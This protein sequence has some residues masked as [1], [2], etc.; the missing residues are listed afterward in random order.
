MK[1]NFAFIL[2]ISVFLAQISIVYSTDKKLGLD[3][4][5]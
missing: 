1:T 3:E 2:L 4:Y 5:L